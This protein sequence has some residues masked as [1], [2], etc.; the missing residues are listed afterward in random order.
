MANEGTIRV[1]VINGCTIRV[2]V[3]NEGTIRVEVTSGCTI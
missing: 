3:A 2:E 1:E